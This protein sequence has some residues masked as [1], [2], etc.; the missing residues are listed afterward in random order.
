[1]QAHLRPQ[2]ALINPTQMRKGRAA[3]QSSIAAEC[4][5][6]IAE[7]VKIA[8]RPCPKNSVNLHRDL[9]QPFFGA[10]GPILL[11]PGLSLKFPYLI[12][13]CADLS[14]NFASGSRP[15]GFFLSSTGGSV[16]GAQIS[17]PGPVKRVASFGPSVRFGCKGNY[18]ICHGC[19]AIADCVALQYP[20][21]S[22][23]FSA[24]IR[25]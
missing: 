19:I 17:L 5:R 1:M 2:L 22:G 3:G 16:K 10:V 8:H 7:P 21:H 6:L 24:P 23:E 4:E 15:A 12:F 9:I 20:K 25:P 11:I 18:C 14:R 13:G